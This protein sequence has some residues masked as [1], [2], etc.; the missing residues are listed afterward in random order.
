M[1]KLLKIFA[2][3]ILLV[4]AIKAQDTIDYGL[5]DPRN[6]RCPCHKYQKIADEE[7]K[8]LLASA[9]KNLI[10]LSSGISSSNIESHL[11]NKSFNSPHFSNSNSSGN[12]IVNKKHYLF[13]KRRHKKGIKF[14]P[15][16][17]KITDAKHWKI[18]KGLKKLDA[19]YHWR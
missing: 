14:K 13:F 9:R 17:R 1:K 6:P 3:V 11:Q 10:G 2:T 7:F 8:T 18:W 16:W 15:G 4:P 5:N 12:L 19:C